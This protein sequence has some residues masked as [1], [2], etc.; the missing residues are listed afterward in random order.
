[1]N[2][3]INQIDSKISKLFGGAEWANSQDKTLLP[4]AT[5]NWISTRSKGDLVATT[6]LSLRRAPVYSM[7]PGIEMMS[8]ILTWFKLIFES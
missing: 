8:V 4:K 3:K 2:L 5:T 1:M 6:C 7:I